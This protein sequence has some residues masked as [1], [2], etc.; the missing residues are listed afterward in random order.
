MALE[1]V[2]TQ[3]LIQTKPTSQNQIG[4]QIKTRN[5]IQNTVVF[6]LAQTYNDFGEEVTFPE[7]VSKAYVTYF[8]EEGSKKFDQVY[9]RFKPFIEASPENEASLLPR[10]FYHISRRLGYYPSR[11][12]AEIAADAFILKHGLPSQYNSTH[13]QLKR[14]A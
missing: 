9:K 2:L 11:A 5:Y 14:A 6:M 1:A 10:L 3:P 7:S 13:Y 8:G 12:S 4:T